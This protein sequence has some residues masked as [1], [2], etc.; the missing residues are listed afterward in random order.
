MRQGLTARME[1]SVAPDD[2]MTLEIVTLRERPELRSLIFA[3]HFQQALFPEFMRHDPVAWLYYAPHCLDR[4]LDYVLVGRLGG[5]VVARAFS[6]PFRLGDEDRH[7]LP[8]GGWDAVIRWAHEDHSRGRAANAVSALE[9]GIAPHAR[10][11]GRSRQ[12]LEAMKANTRARGFSDLYAPVRPNEKHRVPFMSMSDYVARARGDG[13]PEDAWLRTHVRVGGR[14]VKIA[15]YAM[16]IVGSLRE[17]AQWT[18]LTF[19]HTGP[20]AIEGALS[21]VMISIEGDIGVYVEPGVWVHH[22]L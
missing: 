14:V 4:Y 2:A 20:V 6:V 3:D 13:L 12:M 9:I 22:A 17:W 1:R 8:D 15:P 11:A 16:T 19:T 21:P 18:G 10:G 5:E 7:E